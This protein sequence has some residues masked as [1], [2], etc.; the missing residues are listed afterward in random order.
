MSLETLLQDCTV[1]L[2]LPHQEGWGTGFF[3]A[4]GCILTCAHVVKALTA[5][6]RVQVQW[7]QQVNFAE[8]EVI[9][10]APELDLALLKVMPETLN[11]VAD[12]PCVCL[13]EELSSGQE[14][15][16]FGYPDQDF[17]HGC[18]VTGSY[19]GL[20][21]DVPPL[22]KFKLGQVRPG[23]SG[24]AL[25]NCQTGKVCGM[26]KFTRDR[27]SDLG[28]GAIPVSVILQWFPQLKQFQQNFHDQDQR[29][30]DMLTRKV[31]MNIMNDSIPNRTDIKLNTEKAEVVTGKVD[32][33]QIVA[34]TY[35]Q[36]NNHAG[37]K[38]AVLIFKIDPS[39]QTPEE[40]NQLINNML[41]SM[42]IY[43]DG[44]LELAYH[45]RGS[46]KL[47][48]SGLPEDIAELQ[49]LIKSKELTQI[50]GY[51]ISEIQETTPEEDA[52][53]SLIQRIKKGKSIL[54]AADLSG[55][56]L[57]DFS[58]QYLHLPNQSGANRFRR[59]DL[60]D[61]LKFYLPAGA[62]A[63]LRMADLSGADLGMADLGMA[64]LERANLSRANLC[65]TYL[66]VANLIRADLSEADLRRADLRGAD[67]SGANLKGANLKGAD[68]SEADLAGANLKG[69]N[70]E[71]AIVLE[72]HFGKNQGIDI[73]L[74]AS[75]R[76][77]GAIFDDDAPGGYGFSILTRV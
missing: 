77:K 12:L 44:T 57:R 26:V 70:L 76:Q 22:I 55:V 8:A 52:K 10:E 40:I 38:N 66:V 53:I 61:D 4:P 20:T 68:L 43:G 1:K 72:A 42:N 16:F 45:L 28:G 5:P 6:G 30:H 54:R 63:D 73:A 37:T 17:P 27:A 15:Y 64:D 67:L 14:L 69:A 74:A 23:M 47:F 25:L 59:A 46:I 32:G 50:E 65:E 24:S 13:D 62:A 19:E 35:I 21:G 9:E 2:S 31:D 56:D 75:L 29:W 71:N 49:R 33:D 60:G 58:N 39:K 41:N 51:D 48:L 18:P 11:L 34:E 7:Q 36:V 3:V